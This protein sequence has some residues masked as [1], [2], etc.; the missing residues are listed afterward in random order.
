LFIWWIE[1]LI[2]KFSQE[3]NSSCEMVISYWLFVSS[4]TRD[5]ELTSMAVF[6]GFDDTLQILFGQLSARRKA[7]P[8]T[9]KI[10]AH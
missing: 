9:K 4:A 8:P 6:N 3:G 1:N 7:Q 10:L 5:N 2:E